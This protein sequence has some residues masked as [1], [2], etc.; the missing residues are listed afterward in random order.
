MRIFLILL[1][2]FFLQS[3]KQTG[4]KYYIVIDV[5]KEKI[6]EGYP[7][8]FSVIDSAFFANDTTAAWEGERRKWSIIKENK[9]LDYYDGTYKLNLLDENKHDVLERLP[10]SF[11]DRLWSY[12]PEE[13]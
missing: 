3:C 2:P 10:D 11:K 1:I 6:K 8:S 4:R 13:K 9:T 5:E 12:V 7:K